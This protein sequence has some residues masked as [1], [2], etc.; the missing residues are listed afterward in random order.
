MGSPGFW[1]D[2]EAA[3]KVGAEHARIG[4]RLETYDALSRK[5]SVRN[6]SATGSKRAE[7]VYDTVAGGL[8]TTSTG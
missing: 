7:W 5:T 2:P 8:G 4:R 3:G 6:G 1:D